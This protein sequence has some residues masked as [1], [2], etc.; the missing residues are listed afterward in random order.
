M[1]VVVGDLP[2]PVAETIYLLL[3]IN[4][5]IYVT[6]EFFVLN[7]NNKK[8]LQTLNKNGYRAI[9]HHVLTIIN[10]TVASWDRFVMYIST[11]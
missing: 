3:S 9:S 5:G 7:T 2:A 6:N 11:K 8:R 10:V 1:M 4:S